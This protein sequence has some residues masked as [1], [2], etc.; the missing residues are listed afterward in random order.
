MISDLLSFFLR[1]LLQDKLRELVSVRLGLHIQVKIVVSTNI[2]VERAL[3]GET[4]AR[5]GALR[6]LHRD[7]CLREAGWIIVNL[8]AGT[9]PADL[10][11]VDFLVNKQDAV[12]QVHLQVGCPRTGHHLK[13]A[14]GQLG[15]VQPQVLG[16]ISHQRAMVRLLRDRVTY[17]REHSIR[18]AQDNQKH[19]HCR[20]NKCTWVKMS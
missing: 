4:G 15:E 19:N 1:R 18:D 6:D 7:I 3:Q 17:L 8:T 13:A 9:L 11:P 20:E 14:G 2:R 5:S 16:N 10:L 12:L